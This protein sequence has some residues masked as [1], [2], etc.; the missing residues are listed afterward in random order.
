MPSL[1][2]YFEDAHLNMKD[3]LNT[4]LRSIK[5]DPVEMWNNI[6]DAIASVYLAK[7]RLISKL[8]HVVAHPR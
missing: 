4:Y 6:E 5:K 2:G 1:R 8:T 3:T 7:E